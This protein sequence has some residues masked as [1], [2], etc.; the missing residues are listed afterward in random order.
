[1]AIFRYSVDSSAGCCH[2]DEIVL[3]LL[4]NFLLLLFFNLKTLWEDFTILFQ[5][6][7]YMLILRLREMPNIVAM[8]TSFL[9]ENIM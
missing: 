8:V 1:M 2:H 6:K 4:Y 5:E 9:E 7:Q 3:R